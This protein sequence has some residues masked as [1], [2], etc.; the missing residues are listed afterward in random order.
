MPLADFRAL[1]SSKTGTPPSATISLLAGFPPKPVPGL[2]DDDGE[3][4]L[5]DLGL[6]SGDTVTLRADE[7]TGACVGVAALRDLGDLRCL[8]RHP[9]WCFRLL[10]WVLLP[11][12]VPSPTPRC[13]ACICAVGL[14]WGLQLSPLVGLVPA[15]LCPA[16]ANFQLWNRTRAHQK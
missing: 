14:P 3:R 12:Q 10:T 2:H 4:T 1:L 5:G 13:Q 11:P 7:S 9:R 6:A 16:G 8:T 15:F